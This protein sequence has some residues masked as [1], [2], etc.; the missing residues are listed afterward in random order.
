MSSKAHTTHTDPN[1]HSCVQHRAARFRRAGADCCSSGCAS[2]VAGVSSGAMRRAR[3]LLLRCWHHGGRGSRKQSP[4]EGLR[5]AA[6]GLG[7]SPAR[8]KGYTR[9][10][11]R[12]RNSEI[13]FWC[14]IDLQVPSDQTLLVSIHAFMFSSF[15]HE[16]K[17]PCT[18]VPR[19]LRFPDLGQFSYRTFGSL[20]IRN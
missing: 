7:P 9:G 2:Q 16:S 13:S 20:V 15:R 3:T 17:H 11:C 12:L 6:P 4:L 8:R 5:G 19:L 1:T 18:W 14:L 10:A